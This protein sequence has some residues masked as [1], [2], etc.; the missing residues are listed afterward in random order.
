MSLE[1]RLLRELYMP[2]KGSLLLT[3]SELNLL[4]GSSKQDVAFSVAT[5]SPSHFRNFTA[6]GRIL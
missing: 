4:G 3:F 2:S 1:G 5:L 6:S